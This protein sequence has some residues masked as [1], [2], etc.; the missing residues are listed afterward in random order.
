MV[1]VRALLTLMLRG[2]AALVIVS[3]GVGAAPLAAAVGGH[4]AGHH[5]HHHG[6]GAT[7]RHS[8]VAVE[9]AGA[10]RPAE[11]PH[12]ATADCAFLAPCA[13]GS[14]AVGA[15]RMPEIPDAGAARAAADGA[16]ADARSLALA[17]PTPP[18]LAIP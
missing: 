9:A 6:Y 1:A 3:L 12:C 13:D 11:C 5:Q 4:C 10:G 18:P 8:G 7:L 16:A 17:P 14:A 2:A 15:D